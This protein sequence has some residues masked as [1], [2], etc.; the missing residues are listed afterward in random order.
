[1]TKLKVYVT[2]LIAPWDENF[3]RVLLWFNYIVG[4][5]FAL[6]IRWLDC[7]IQEFHIART[8]IPMQIQIP[9]HY[10]AHFWDGY[11]YRIGILALY[12]NVNMPL[13]LLTG[14]EE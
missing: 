1:M 10:C 5:G 11:P 2:R 3:N 6:Q 14:Y 4:L 8:N 7:I 12:G 9:D 13:R